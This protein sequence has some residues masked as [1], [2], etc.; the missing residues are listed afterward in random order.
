MKCFAI[1]LN[2]RKGLVANL[3]LLVERSEERLNNVT[4]L[5]IKKENVMNSY[6]DLGKESWICV[7]QGWDP[8]ILITC[9]H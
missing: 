3:A 1:L 4:N 2:V 9:K 5:I 8:V 6:I 7:F